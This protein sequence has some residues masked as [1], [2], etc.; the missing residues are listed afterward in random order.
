MA[1][2]VITHTGMQPS[3]TD[4]S[5]ARP[6]RVCARDLRPQDAIDL[7]AHPWGQLTVTLSGVVRV[8]TPRSSWVV[9]PQR[10]I[11]IP[12]RMEHA[13]VVLETARLRPL[14]IDASRDPFR[15]GA[16][17][18][19][20]M[21][22]L[23]RALIVALGDADSAAGSPRE[24]MLSEV[25]LDEMQRAATTPMGVPLP[26]DKRLRA[27]C[28]ALIE[29]PRSPR[30]LA[31]WARGVGA[32]ER[33]LGRLFERELGMGFD[34]WRRQLRLAHAAPL[35][36]RG[37]PLSVVAQELGYASQS[38]FTAMFKRTFGAP[39]TAFFAAGPAA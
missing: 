34:Q 14:K 20:E 21:S 19:L 9:P 31:D 3:H 7:H 8:R 29:E 17:R 11:W 24:T 39:P 35:I 5:D 38:A 26:A 22:D 32:S 36:A 23:L 15:D 13:I 12:P 33:T 18:V 2:T 30:T 27:L 1:L 37:L 25:V 4:P 6:V 28:E 16:C 10:A